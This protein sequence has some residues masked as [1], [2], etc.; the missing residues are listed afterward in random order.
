[1]SVAVASPHVRGLCDSDSDA[2]VAVMVF[3][4]DWCVVV[5]VSSGSLLGGMTSL[6]YVADV[7]PVEGSY[8]RPV[9]SP[10]PVASGLAGVAVHCSVVS[11]VCY[12]GTVDVV[13]LLCCEVPEISVCVSERLVVYSAISGSVAVVDPDVAVWVRCDPYVECGERPMSDVGPSWV[14]VCVSADVDT[15]SDLVSADVCVGTV[16]SEEVSGSN[17]CASAARGTA[18]VSP[19]SV[20]PT[21]QCE[22]CC[23]LGW[24]VVADDCLVSSW[25]AEA[26]DCVSAGSCCY[27]D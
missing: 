6:M 4:V 18:P 15:E 19:A 3:D 14:V 7:A 9:A 8:C 27:V 5:S 24:Y 21:G 17:R 23:A 22:W 2:E 10:R 1:M 16:E 13:G 20:G 26:G 12:D 25:Y 11:S